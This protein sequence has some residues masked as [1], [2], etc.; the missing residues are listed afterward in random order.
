MPTTPESYP[1]L[2]PLKMVKPKA[3]VR[4]DPK[5]MIPV[6]TYQRR[7]F[8]KDWQPARRGG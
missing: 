6:E 4:K 7:R 5:G 3:L 8:A 1:S 2:P